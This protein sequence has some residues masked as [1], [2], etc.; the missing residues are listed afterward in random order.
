MNK[1]MDQELRNDSSNEVG[2]DEFQ[3]TYAKDNASGDVSA[4]DEAEKKDVEQSS[5]P[6]SKHADA[7][8]ENIS[9]PVADQKAKQRLRS[10]DALRGYSNQT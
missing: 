2:K 1:S 4:A 8:P 10:L 3:L 5:G 7:A 9:H 6:A